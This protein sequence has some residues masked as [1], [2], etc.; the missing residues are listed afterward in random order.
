MSK[1]GFFSLT[2]YNPKILVGF[3]FPN[4][5]NCF[6]VFVVLATCNLI[7]RASVQIRIE[8]SL[9]ENVKSTPFLT[10]FAL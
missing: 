7:R 6:S 3:E 5:T 2:N 4:L 10:Y 1:M 9:R 8:I